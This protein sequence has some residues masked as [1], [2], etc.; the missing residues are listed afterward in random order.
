MGCPK[1][2]ELMSLRAKVRIFESDSGYS[3]LNNDL[4]RSNRKNQTL[5]KENDCLKAE[6]LQLHRDN[7]FLKETNDDISQRYDV[8][9]EKF[10][11]FQSR[12]ETEELFRSAAFIEK[13]DGLF[14]FLISNNHYHLVILQILNTN[15]H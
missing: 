10:L 1:H 6:N 12:A 3:R 2:S 15:P 14:L 5:A 13:M 7:H 11:Q 4:A 9:V 8:L